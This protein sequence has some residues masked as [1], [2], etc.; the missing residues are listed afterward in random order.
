MFDLLIAVGDAVGGMLLQVQKYKLCI[1]ITVSAHASS[2]WNIS[3]ATAEVV[4]L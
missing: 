1:W 2:L 4:S 3:V